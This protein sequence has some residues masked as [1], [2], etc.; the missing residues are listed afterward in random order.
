MSRQTPW[1]PEPPSPD[2]HAARA[3]AAVAAAERA[4]VAAEVDPQFRAN[5]DRLLGEALTAMTAFVAAIESVQAHARHLELTTGR[6]DPAQAELARKAN[7]QW[8][9][10]AVVFEG[11]GI[12][13]RKADRRFLAPVRRPGFLDRALE[14]LKSHV[15]W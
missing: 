1:A 4:V 13:L 2:S 15:W 10:A 9:R 14:A 12:R 5:A 3:E 11:L 6:R 8:R 7:K